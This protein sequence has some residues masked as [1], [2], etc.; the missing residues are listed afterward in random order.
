MT[1]I[2]EEMFS[3]AEFGVAVLLFKAGTPIEKILEEEEGIAFAFGVNIV[4]PPALVGHPPEPYTATARLLK[5][6]SPESWQGSGSFMVLFVLIGADATTLYYMDN[7]LINNPTTTLNA[8]NLVFFGLL[9]NEYEDG[10]DGGG[11]GEPIPPK[12]VC[13]DC[14]LPADICKC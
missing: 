14:D 3:Q 7:V 2:S 9:E 4:R 12:P 11:S 6:D 13:G 8:A 5:I 10:Y 1:G